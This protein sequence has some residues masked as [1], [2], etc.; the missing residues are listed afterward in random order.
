MEESNGGEPLA[1]DAAQRV[2]EI[3]REVQDAAHFLGTLGDGGW[4]HGAKIVAAAET[5]RA[6]LE[7][8]AQQ[9]TEAT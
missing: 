9:L 2:E 4:N 5:A 1:L 7:Q 8:A 3:R 6:S